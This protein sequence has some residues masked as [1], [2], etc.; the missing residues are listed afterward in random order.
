MNGNYVFKE[1]IGSDGTV[2]NS[3]LINASLGGSVSLLGR[4]VSNDGVINARLGAVNMAAGKEAVLTFESDGLI[5]VR[6]TKAILQDELG[7]DAAVI[8][9][10][11]IN[12]NGGRVLLT[13]SVSR[14]VFSQA[15]NHDGIEQA[16]SV[17]MH[18][19]GSFT[20]GGGADVLN[21]GA[22][23]VSANDTYLAGNVVVLGEN[24]LHTG[25]IHADADKGKAGS[26]ELHAMDK[27]EL[28]DNA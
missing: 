10:G 12:A 23:N 21:T 28:R 14:D 25:S 26:I 2:I 3:G 27:T 13:G 1:L 20:L 6:V 18:D 4:Q 11:E 24:I 15:V 16:T 7:I 19:D 8:N 17:V 5:G 22:V 9:N